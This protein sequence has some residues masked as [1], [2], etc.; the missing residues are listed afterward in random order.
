MQ[1]MQMMAKI[2]ILLFGAM[3]ILSACC[4]TV[5]SERNT[6]KIDTLI[7]RISRDSLRLV[8]PATITYV[9]D[10]VRFKDTTY[11]KDKVIAYVDT[12]I[13]VYRNNKLYKDSLRLWFDE[14]QQKFKIDYVQPYD[15][16]YRYVVTDYKE[17]TITETQ[18]W[19]QN[20][21]YL[22]LIFLFLVIIGVAVYLLRR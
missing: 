14:L 4:P 13:T 18:P 3:L 11:I 21:L 22:A 15:T 9:R 16:T 20:V 10:T 5:V 6:Q 8:L 1:G 19:Y 17:K 7:E 2:T 12:V